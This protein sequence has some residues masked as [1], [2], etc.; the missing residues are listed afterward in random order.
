[1]SPTGGTVERVGDGRGSYRV[2][3]RE[4]GRGKVVK[5]LEGIR[6]VDDGEIRRVVERTWRSA[7]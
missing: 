5:W 1:M 3:A 7:P 2:E 4:R 6:T